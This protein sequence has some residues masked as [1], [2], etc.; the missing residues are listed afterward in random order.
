MAK[1]RSSGVPG[2]AIAATIFGI[3]FV[4]ALVAAIIFYTQA[5]DMTRRALAAESE[6]QKL[7]T[8]DDL[9]RPEVR[10][11]M[12]APDRGA[13]VQQLLTEIEALRRAAAGDTN[14]DAANLRKRM[15]ADPFKLASGANLLDVI[16][17]LQA[18][19]RSRTDQAAQAERD[20][21]AARQQAEEAD[22]ARAE[23]A[24]TYNASVEQLKSQIAQLN[25][26]HQS[27]R[28][29]VETSQQQLEERIASVRA[30]LE[31]ELADARTLLAQKDQQI[32]EKD[33]QIKRLMEIARPVVVDNTIRPDGQITATVP[34]EGLVYVN[35]GRQKHVLPGMTFEVFG[36]KEV[37]K[38]DEFNEIRG[39]ATI[40]IV[41]VQPDTASARVVRSE[42]GAVVREGDNIVN[43]AFDPNVKFKFYVYGDFDVDNT[44]TPSL[45]DR[46]R[47]ES[48]VSRFG[49]TVADELSY[50]VDYLVLG[51]E[52][53]LPAPLPPDTLD[54]ELI[55]TYETQKRKFETYQQ[56]IG[57]ATALKIPILNQNRFLALVGYYQR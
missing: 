12:E 25:Q 27:F 52:P 39:K 9:L 31:Q 19:L 10:A 7:A 22:K 8:A 53:T 57:E 16:R 43:L 3:L 42:R 38:P 17:A 51:A 15:E 40:E 48:M 11:A 2:A 32:A 56:L 46:K 50:E 23:L 49:A 55:R 20:L 26:T 18:E 1:A 35:L 47:I 45:G 44:G 24:S 5:Q 36:P 6:R 34:Q 29:S 4:F 28:Q 41:D 37:V 13:V 21:A 30:E 14:V 54:P 33:A